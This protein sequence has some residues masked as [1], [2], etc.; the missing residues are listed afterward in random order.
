MLCVA[1]AIACKS[2][3]AKLS[4]SH[5][6]VPHLPALLIRYFSLQLFV[7]FSL[8]VKCRAEL[9]C[10]QHPSSFLPLLNSFS[11]NVFIVIFFSNSIV[12]SSSVGCY[13]YTQT[14]SRYLLYEGRNKA[15]VQCL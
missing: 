10:R 6:S 15:R 1:R 11:T 8:V 7:R 2:P 4:F 12:I 14:A 5:T 13:V 9:F 3:G